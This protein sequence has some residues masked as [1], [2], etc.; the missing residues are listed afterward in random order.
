MDALSVVVSASMGRG[1]L[2]VL[3]LLPRDGR[4]DGTLGRM[5]VRVEP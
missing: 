5:T 2:V 3:A 4:V 1:W